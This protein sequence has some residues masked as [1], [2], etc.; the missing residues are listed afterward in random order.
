[1]P[2]SFLC[3]H[4]ILS[5]D[6][7]SLV[8]AIDCRIL[9]TSN[10]RSPVV[11]RII[12]AHPIQVLHSPSLDELLVHTDPRYP[13]SKTFAEARNEPLL[14]VHTSGT[15]AVPKPIAYSHDFAAS[16]IQNGQLDP[17]PGY[18]SQV[19]LCQSNRF[20]VAL[21]FFHVSLHK[22]VYPV[23]PFCEFIHWCF[24]LG[25]ESFRDHVR[26]HC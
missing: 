22:P 15:T 26:C 18:E 4:V 24:V 1:M 19:S 13:Y 16:Q 9:L 25:W 17:P 21:P 2:S 10:P 23:E 12:V 5:T 6:R 3:L 14:V 20:F 11:Q 7:A 8:E